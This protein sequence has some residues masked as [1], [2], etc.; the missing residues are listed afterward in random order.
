MRRFR[1][2]WRS[3]EHIT[4][5]VEGEPSERLLR[6]LKKMLRRENRLRS[7]EG[8]E[9]FSYEINISSPETGPEM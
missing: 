7:G 5:T 2:A 9:R 3:W 1:T 4:V 8:K 6:G